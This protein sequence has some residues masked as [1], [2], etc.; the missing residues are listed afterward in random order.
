MGST[1]H[2]DALGQQLAG[3][4]SV[5][6]PGHPQ[7]PLRDA[8]F[9]GIG[10]MSGGKV[11]VCRVG[12]LV[13]VGWEGWYMSGGKVAN[14]DQHCHEVC[15]ETV[16]VDHDGVRAVHHGGGVQAGAEPDAFR[17]CAHGWVR[18]WLGVV[19]GAGKTAWPRL[20]L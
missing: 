20:H 10:G 18:V 1:T 15:A 8:P 7:T 3:I 5:L 13:Q 19:T 6:A 9:D 17:T 2:R 14:E 12:R 11:G 16:A 4:M